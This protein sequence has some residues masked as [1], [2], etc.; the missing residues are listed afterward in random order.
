M[1]LTRFDFCQRDFKQEI[2]PVEENVIM[3][4]EHRER[5]TNTKNKNIKKLKK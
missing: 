1:H 2:L 5:F 4:Q 3:Y